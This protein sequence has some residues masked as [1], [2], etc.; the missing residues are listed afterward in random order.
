VHRLADG[1]VVLASFVGRELRVRHAAPGAPFGP[2]QLLSR[3]P[4][5]STAD[6]AVMASSSTGAL[7]IAWRES[8]SGR[9]CVRDWCFDRVLA[10]SAAPGQPFGPPQLLSPLGTRTNR[11]V[12]A[13]ADDGRRL[14]AW[15]GAPADAFA[16]NRLAIAR[17]NA[18][19]DS[20]AVADRTPPRVRVLDSSIRDGKLRLRLRSN[21][22]VAVRTFVGDTSRGRAV[23]LPARRTRT[24]VWS[25][26]TYQRAQRSVSIV[27]ADAAGNVTRL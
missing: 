26:T 8:I 18:A 10:A 13:L 16:P 23:V 14:V 15:L 4:R 25:L 21:E 5:D 3:L 20:P 24:F 11:I 2:P 1:G 22:P 12:A 17:G 9:G 6:T 27:A 7:L 19:T